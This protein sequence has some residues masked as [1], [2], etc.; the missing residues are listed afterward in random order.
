[1]VLSTEMYEWTIGLEFSPLKFNG[2]LRLK[3]SVMMNSVTRSLERRVI[4]DENDVLQIGS[5]LYMVGSVRAIESVI[6]GTIL[7]AVESL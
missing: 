7:I 4:Y 1:M 3:Q 6:V 2:V 5:D